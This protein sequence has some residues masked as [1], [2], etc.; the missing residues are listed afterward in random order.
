[1]SV[2]GETLSPIAKP[3]II[4]GAR[5]SAYVEP[6]S[7]WVS[8]NTPAVPMTMPVTTIAFT[9]SLGVS[10]PVTTAP[11]NTAPASGSSRTP[12]SRAS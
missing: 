4:I 9:P 7:T 3:S 12:V 8:R 5:K 10:F 1:M 2:A 6:L 11:R